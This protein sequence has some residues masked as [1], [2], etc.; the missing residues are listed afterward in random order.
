[1]VYDFSLQVLAQNH[2]ALLILCRDNCG[3]LPVAWS[4]IDAVAPANHTHGCIGFRKQRVPGAVDVN[5][6]VCVK[7]A[8][9]LFDHLRRDNELSANR[10]G[11]VESRFH[12]RGNCGYVLKI[13]RPSEGFI[14]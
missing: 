10:D 6:G 7:E 13:K 11:L 3:S 9:P 2:V 5:L 1:M 8:T 12:S 14:H 4:G